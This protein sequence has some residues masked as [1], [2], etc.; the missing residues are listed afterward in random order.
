[1]SL[2][3]CFIIVLNFEYYWWCFKYHSFVRVFV[4]VFVC[5]LFYSGGGNDEG[6]DDNEEEEADEDQH[7]EDGWMMSDGNETYINT[8]RHRQNDDHFVDDIFKWI[9]L[10]EIVRIQSKFHC[11]LFPSVRLTIFQVGAKPFSEPMMASF[12]DAYMR[13]LGL[14][15]LKN[16]I[17]RYFIVSASSIRQ[18]YK[19]VGKWVYTVS[20][21]WMGVHE[22]CKLTFVISTDNAYNHYLCTRSINARGFPY[23]SALCVVSV[24]RTTPC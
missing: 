2:A 3:S 6:D 5:L 9:F 20:H 11:S 10:G 4:C 8:L 21:G 13:S 22:T 7:E 17:F 12:T 1:M 15:E 18:M 16:I 24:A 14:N 19:R 23:R